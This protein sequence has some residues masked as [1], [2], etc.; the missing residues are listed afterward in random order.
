MAPEPPSVYREKWTVRPLHA[1]CPRRMD[2][3][4]SPRG[5]SS[6]PQATRNTWLNGSNHERTRTSDKLDEHWST[7]TIRAYQADC[8]PGEQQPEHENK[9]STPPIHPWI[10]Q[11]TW[12]LETR[13]GGDVKRPQGLLCPKNWSL[14]TTKSLGIEV[15]P[16]SHKELGFQ[17]KSFNQRPNLEFEESR[18][19]TKMHYPWSPQTNPN[20]NTSESKEQA[21][22]KI[23]WK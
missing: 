5:L 3:P 9:K 11:T 10:S 21:A 12:A 8:P 22:Q 23:Q 15:L 4:C 7:R 6:K 20:P 1:D 18:S 16:S 2:C 17:T 13:F 19:S 14:K